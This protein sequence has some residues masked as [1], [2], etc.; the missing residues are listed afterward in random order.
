MTGYY[1][2]SLYK[3][4]VLQRWEI[5]PMKT[6]EPSTRVKYFKGS[7]DQIH[8][9][10][11]HLTPLTMQKEEQILESLSGS[12]DNLSSHWDS[13]PLTHV[14]DFQKWKWSRLWCK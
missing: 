13:T 2:G 11:L 1:A 14:P 8:A 10:T 6:Q 9:E 3:T 12:E 5:D 7:S 4:H